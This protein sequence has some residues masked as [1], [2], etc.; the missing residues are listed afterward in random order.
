ME[1][2]LREYKKIPLPFKLSLI[3]ILLIRIIL[4]TQP[5][6]KIDMND[7]QAWAARLVDTGPMK[8]YTPNIFADYLPFYYFFLWII[9]EIFSF[10]FGKAAIFSTTF[11]IYI[12]VISNIF[13]VLTASTIFVII[14]KYSKKWAMIGSLLYLINP[15][16]IFNSSVWGQIDAIPTFL[17]TYSLYQLGERKNIMQSSVAAALSFLIKP[18]N[19]SI[20]PIMLVREIK[21]FSIKKIIA[22]ISLAILVSFAIIIFFFPSDP[23]FGALGHLFNSINMYPYTSLNAYNFWAIFGWWK[24]DATLWFNL[25]YHIWGYVLYVLVLCIIF[26]PYLR[27]KVKIGTQLDYF[28]CALSSFGFFL[29]LTRI[30]ERHLFPVF[31]LLIIS[32]CI[33]RSRILIVS[34]IVLAIINFINLFYSYYYYNVIYNNP[35][36]PKNIIFDISSNYQLL[37][38]VLSLVVFAIMFVVYFE[39]QRSVIKN[40]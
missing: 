15:S 36:A 14:N 27:K 21:S 11:E 12:K 1:K 9:A 35:I 39:N 18:L 23:I 2:V 17:L 8:F 3:L 28:A 34:Y 19:I 38:S 37:F 24:P 30:H 31:A 16:T 22:S 25:S 6:F 4:L 5:S 20:L 33:F 29:F 13:D 40:K 26:V 10:I 32:A 7:W